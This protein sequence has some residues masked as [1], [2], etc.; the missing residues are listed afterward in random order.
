[1]KP[2]KRNIRG[3]IQSAE[4]KRNHA[5][6][7]ASHAIEQFEQEGKKINFALIAQTAQVS[8]AWLYRQPVI[9]QRIETLRV[10]Y[11]NSSSNGSRPDQKSIEM[12][13][14]L[15]NKI[16]KLKAENTELKKQ[17]EIVYG[18]LHQLKN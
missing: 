14:S 9:R 16:K 5:L 12:M 18:Q 1:M 7:R 10:Q 3:L 13:A 8:I 4:D 2:H 6:Q 15:K 11:L 17:L